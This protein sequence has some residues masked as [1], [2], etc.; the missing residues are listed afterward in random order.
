MGCPWRGG[1]T[2]GETLANGL[3]C[4]LTATDKLNSWGIER[5]GP[6]AGI[7]AMGQITPYRTFPFHN[8]GKP[9]NKMK[10]LKN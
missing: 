4:E 9:F 5:L 10:Y 7:W 2:W 6:E 1:K 3:S 8:I